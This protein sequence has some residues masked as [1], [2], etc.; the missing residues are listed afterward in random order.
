MTLTPSSTPEEVREAW[1][2]RLE[3]GQDQQTQGRLGRRKP[4]GTDCFCGLG[5]LVELA[6][7]AGV[8]VREDPTYDHGGFYYKSAERDENWTD[9]ALPSAVAEWADL[10][11]DPLSSIYEGGGPLLFTELNDMLGMDFRE[12]GAQVRKDF[13]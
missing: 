13:L 6:V 4:D 2:T 12:I 7:E 8:A 9:W 5:V 11:I 1:A 3:S 10:D